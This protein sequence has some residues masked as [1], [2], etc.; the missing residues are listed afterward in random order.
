M[1]PTEQYS[2]GTLMDKEFVKEV[3]RKLIQAFK[4]AD[5][6]TILQ[7]AF[8]LTLPQTLQYIPSEQEEVN[9]QTVTIPE[10]INLVSE[11]EEEKETDENDYEEPPSNHH[12][13]EDD[14]R[15]MMMPLHQGQEGLHK[16]TMPQLLK[17]TLRGHHKNPLL[18][19]L[20]NLP[21]HLPNK[22]SLLNK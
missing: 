5:G 19:L 8:K 10:V 4:Q 9:G 20:R 14:K 15:M 13:D 18:H 22:K 2:F 6:Q 1:F 11:D 12:K 21:I 16:E 3:A 17:S 7:M